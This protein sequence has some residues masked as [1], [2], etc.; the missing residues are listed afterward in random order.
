MA[1]RDV[2]FERRR[3]GSSGSIGL[4]S[5]GFDYQSGRFVGA[6]RSVTF[7]QLRCL[8]V[9]GLPLLGLTACL[10]AA[11][12][13]EER[14]RIPPFLIVPSVSPAVDEVVSIATNKAQQIRVPFRSEDLGEPLT[15]VF[16]LNGSFQGSDAIGPSVFDDDRRAVEFTLRPEVDPGCY[17]LSMVLT[18]RS[19]LIEGRNV[20]DE[21]MAAYLYWWVEIFD[22]Q[23]GATSVCLG[24]TP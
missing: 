14:E 5:C 3:T 22:P 10:D 24:G 17:Q 19:N 23:L 18:H 12:T 7:K 13:Y 8:A 4:A 16:A 6:H 21:S 20:Y 9:A 2:P 15:A 11:P 1:Q